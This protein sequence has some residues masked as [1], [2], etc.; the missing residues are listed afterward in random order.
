MALYF[1]TAITE[2]IPQTTQATPLRG[3]SAYPPRR[4]PG[5]PFFEHAVIVTG[6]SSGVGREIS[7]LLAEQGAWLTLASR[8]AQ[9]LELVADECRRRG[10]RALV[11][12]TDVAREYQCQ[13]LIRRTVET[14]G[15]IDM[16]I[17]NAGYGMV[18]P[19]ERLTDFSQVEALMQVNFMGALY[20]TAYALP[21]LRR[22]A[23]RIVAVSS[24]AGRIGLPWNSAYSA[25]KHA[26]AGFFD[27]LRSE[28]A[29]SGVTVTV[30]YPSFLASNFHNRMVGPD[31]EPLDVD[32]STR[33]NGRVMSAQECARHVIRAAARRRRELVLTF[34]G[35]LGVWLRLLWPAFLDHSV[36]RILTR[37]NS[38]GE[39]V[40]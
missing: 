23:G 38:K 10:A 5:A 12:P 37:A 15:R 26:L 14:H 39:P 31:G 13:R 17:N 19:L 1:S 25:S 6:A 20:C 35:K 34:G 36:R 22:S 33:L 30:I 11:M 29:D 21:H 16:L 24:L 2:N 4:R 40:L 9:R 7:L 3:V 28:L 27:S 8:N 18:A 32:I